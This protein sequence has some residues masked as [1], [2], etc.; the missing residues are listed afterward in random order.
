VGL[1]VPETRTM[2]L[3]L[4]RHV[5]SVQ[6]FG[7]AKSHFARTVSQR[8][9]AISNAPLAF[10]F[11]GFVSRQKVILHRLCHRV[12]A[13]CFCSTNYPPSKGLDMS[14]MVYLVFTMTLLFFAWIDGRKT[15]RSKVLQWTNKSIMWHKANT[16]RIL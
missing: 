11:R 10:L 3:Y 9:V 8:V 6:L 1:V 12:V 5:Q 14:P 16:S 2:G 4:R 13:I 7:T 15:P